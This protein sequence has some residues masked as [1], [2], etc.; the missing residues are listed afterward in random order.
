[1]KVSRLILTAA[2]LYV[3]TRA[4]RKADDDADDERQHGEAQV[5][6]STSQPV[7][8]G[9]MPASKPK[10]AKPITTGTIPPG[11]VAPMATKSNK[12]KFPKRNAPIRGIV[13]HHSHTATPKATQNA[14]EAKGLST[15]Y[16]VDQKG[17]ILVYGD[18]ANGFAQATGAGANRYLIAIDVTHYPEDAPFPEVQVEATRQ[19][20]QWLSKRFNFQLVLAPDGV[21]KRWPQWA[22]D[23]APPTLYRH[24]NFVSTQCPMF[25]P[26]GRLL[27]TGVLA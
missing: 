17:N 3:L 5:Q 20:V 15:N 9:F 21:R 10:S 14:L 7:G 24:R 12:M 25:F 23:P 11:F 4:W 16:E 27:E 2:G 13:I 22:A 6:E 18:P 8:S 26:M 1:M 19:L